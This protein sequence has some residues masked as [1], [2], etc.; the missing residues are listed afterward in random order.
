[1]TDFPAISGIAAHFAKVLKD[2]YKTGLWESRLAHELL[3]SLDDPVWLEIGPHSYQG[4]SWS[5]AAA[6]Q[7][8]KSSPTPLID[9]CFKVIDCHISLPNKGLISI[10]NNSEFGAVESGSLTVQGRL[11]AA[12]WHVRHREDWMHPRQSNALYRDHDGSLRN[13]LA[14]VMCPD[15]LFLDL[16]IAESSITVYLLNV[17][18]S[19]ALTQWFRN[20]YSEGGKFAGLVLRRISST[21]YTRLGVFEYTW[22]SRWD[23]EMVKKFES[24]LNWLETG[25]VRTVT[26]V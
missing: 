8:I 10:V 11:R 16:I 13:D 3:W 7:P 26:I 22:P 23:F 17:E 15:S 25:E 1:M 4:S 19:T 21:A 5:W 9:E 18:K 2:E 14:A 12:T 6:N 24:D 20:L